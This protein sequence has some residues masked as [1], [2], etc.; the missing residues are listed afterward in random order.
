MQINK[1]VFIHD[2]DKAALDALKAIPGFT[3][4]LRTFMKIWDEKLLQIYNMSQKVRLSENQL[5]QY[6]HMLPPICDKLG[7]DI[8]E[9]YLELNVMPNAY[10]TG[11]TKPA[12]TITSG[13]LE[14]VPDELIPTVLAHECGHIVCH[15]ALYTTMGH[16]ILS[17]AVTH[18]PL[19]MI[20]PAL[21]AAFSYWMRCSE[22]SADRA[23]ILC[24]GGTNKMDELL[25]R[26]AGFDKDIIH[27]ANLEAF[28]MQADE[29][30]E[31]VSDSKINKAMEFYTFA[32]NDHP[33]HVVRLK[34]ANK[35]S[36]SEDFIKAQ[37]YFEAF[38][39]D[40]QPAEMPAQWNEKHF[41]GRPYD[42]VEQE[43]YD[44]GFYDVDMTRITE[45]PPLFTKEKSVT[46]VTI[47]GSDKYKESDW[48]SA[49]ASVEVT[50][51]LPL[52]DEEVAAMHPGEI[53]LPNSAKSYKGKDLDSVKQEL[54]D[55]GFFNIT[56]EE[57]KDIKKENDK[58]IGKVKEI[59]FDRSPLFKKGD[60]I[61]EEAEVW[62]SYHSH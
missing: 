37:Q 49:A 11:D 24:D 14:T 22:Y 30:E 9:L 33:V 21:A 25:M 35:W 43:L 48:M 61:R 47:N 10:T 41:I 62:I 57:I 58:N 51:Y 20:T 60:W 50:Y 31:L 29:Y 46:N 54:T 55:L 52:S 45:N 8:P 42:E 15:H 19:G 27:N 18:T 28:I 56:T 26:L 6:Y 36:Q 12:I 34:E 4:L 16:I 3:P 53:K 7:I 23:A 39:K 2:S 44:F 5:P 32:F 59:M 1:N 40:E 13:L 17:N 38:N